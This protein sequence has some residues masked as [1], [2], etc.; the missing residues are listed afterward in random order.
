MR[1]SRG[2]VRPARARGLAPRVGPRIKGGPLGRRRF[3][4]P[5]KEED[6][7]HWHLSAGLSRGPGIAHPEAVTVAVAAVQGAIGAAAYD[8]LSAMS[9]ADGTVTPTA[10]S[11]FVASNR[12][13]RR[14]A[15][16]QGFQF[17]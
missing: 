5:M 11:S 17:H 7:G 12:A 9:T 10:P 15:A 4:I 3:L 8:S 13:A 16:V 2:L 6:R 1:R 14:I